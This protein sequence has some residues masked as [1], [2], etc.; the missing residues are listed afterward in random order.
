MTRINETEDIIA[1]AIQP[2][3]GMPLNI[4]EEL[5]PVTAFMPL[6]TYHVRLFVVGE[7]EAL[8]LSSVFVVPLKEK[9][10]HQN[11]SQKGMHNT[12]TFDVLFI[13]LRIEPYIFFHHSIDDLVDDCASVTTAAFHLRPLLNLELRNEESIHVMDMRVESS[14]EAQRWVERLASILCE[15]FTSEP[16]P[17]ID[18]RDVGPLLQ[19]VVHHS[20]VLVDSDRTRRVDE[21]PACLG[22]WRDTVDRTQDELLLKVGKECEI[23]ICLA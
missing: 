22:F 6:L 23:T 18:E 14:R 10:M 7:H 13:F 20:F 8:S 16:D 11:R 1:I 15:P 9:P 19:C 12:Q 21:A 5:H 3:K 4:T 17:S 2:Y